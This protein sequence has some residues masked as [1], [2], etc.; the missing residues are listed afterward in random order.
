M[1]AILSESRTDKR[2]VMK[3]ES[4]EL[5]EFRRKAAEAKKTANTRKASS[6][7]G[8]EASD[9]FFELLGGIGLLVIA[10]AW[11]FDLGPFGWFD[12]TTPKAPTAAEVAADRATK[13]MYVKQGGGWCET[14]RAAKL[15]VKAAGR[16]DTATINRLLMN[17]QCEKIPANLP[18]AHVEGI[19][20]VL[21]RDGNGDLHWTGSGAIF[22]Q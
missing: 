1:T 18:V 2:E 14:E 10:V 22:Y 8:S 5:K 12:K 6:I 20:I 11:L 7:T 13:H 16:G 4:E 21:V 19:S 15:L 3:N 9:K 17:G